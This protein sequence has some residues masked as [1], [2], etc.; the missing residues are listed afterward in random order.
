MKYLVEFSGPAQNGNLPIV[1][2]EAKAEVEGD[3]VEKLTTVEG[4]AEI[5][6]A[7]A[8]GTQINVIDKAV[9][10]D[11]ADSI[12]WANGLHIVDANF[13]D[14]PKSCPAHFWYKLDS[15]DGNLTNISVTVTPKWAEYFEEALPSMIG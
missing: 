3:V 1:A 15:E 14:N 10:E 5:I 4:L 9:W 2:A 8:Y 11:V 12:T 6:V 7:A 13:T